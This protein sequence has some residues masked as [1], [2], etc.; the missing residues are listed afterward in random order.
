MQKNVRGGAKATP[1]R[2]LS[3]YCQILR[4]MFSL[5]LAG[6]VHFAFD[7]SGKET[8]FYLAILIYKMGQNSSGGFCCEI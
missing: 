3:V 1:R 8:F 4:E 5:C 2:N 7:S 6:E